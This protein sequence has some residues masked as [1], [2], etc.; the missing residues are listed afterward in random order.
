ALDR[1]EVAIGGLDE[2]AARE[3]WTSLEESFGPTRAGAVEAAIARTR[4]MPLALRRE[5]ARAMAGASAPDPWDVAKL[6]EATR[7]VLEALVVLR[8]PAA[9]AA[10]AAVCGPGPVDVETPLAD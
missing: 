9:P 8:M 5:Y 7:R 6:P 1:G 10:I 3:L 2:P 4:G